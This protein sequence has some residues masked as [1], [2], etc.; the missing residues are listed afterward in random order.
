[1]NWVT[2]SCQN[3]KNLF[4]KTSSSLF[5]LFRNQYK[6]VIHHHPIPRHTRHE[7]QRTTAE[8]RRTRNM[9]VQQLSTEKPQMLLLAH[10]ICV[11]PLTF[12]SGF[13]FQRKIH[14]CVPPL[15]FDRPTAQRG[16]HHVS[17]RGIFPISNLL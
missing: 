17:L 4:S 13:N 11:M 10:V 16:S 5:N 1:M 7:Q 8:T 12:P 9:A 3:L 14:N 2:N 6:K 15:P